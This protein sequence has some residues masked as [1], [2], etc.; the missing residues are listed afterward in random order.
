MVFTIIS[1]HFSQNLKDTMRIKLTR[2]KIFFLHSQ[3]TFTYDSPQWDRK[4]PYQVIGDRTEYKLP[5]YWLNPFR[6]LRFHEVS[7][8]SQDKYAHESQHQC[9]FALLAVARG[10]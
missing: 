10:C 1:S 2:L 6:N 8:R 5:G 4:T 9:K 7:N 3:N